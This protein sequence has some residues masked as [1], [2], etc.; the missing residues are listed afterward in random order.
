ML[1]IDTQ[2][3]QHKGSG[4]F[5]FLVIDVPN[6][7]KERLVAKAEQTKHIRGLQ[8]IDTL[9]CTACSKWR[10]WNSSIT[11][12]GLVQ[13]KEGKITH[14]D[15]CPWFD[16]DDMMGMMMWVEDSNRVHPVKNPLY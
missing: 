10:R 1:T 15:A 14:I 8:P 12:W 4:V 5:R 9:E 11:V 16:G 13:T 3:S 2:D 6:D 7:V